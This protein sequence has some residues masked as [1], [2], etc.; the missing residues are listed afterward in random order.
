V[1]G[2]RFS[3]SAI[4][5]A[6]AVPLWV[7]ALLAFAVALLAAAAALPKR[8][9]AGL[10]ASLLLGLVGATILLGLTITYALG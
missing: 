5:L 6:E 10:S 3:R 8:Q 9:T 7:Y 1:L 2:A 4:S